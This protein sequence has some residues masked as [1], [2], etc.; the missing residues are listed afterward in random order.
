MNFTIEPRRRIMKALALT[1][2][3]VLLASACGG[4][5]DSAAPT[6]AVVQTTSA[7][8][9]A[10]E[11]HTTT[12][13]GPVKLAAVCTF[14]ESVP[15]IT[16]HASGA[17]Q[18]SQLRWD[19]NIWGWNTGPSYEIR[20]EQEHQ[21]VPQVV[22][23]LQECRG[24]TCET[25]ETTIATSIIA[26]TS[27]RETGSATTVTPT[28]AAQTDIA[29]SVRLTAL[30]SFDQ[31]VPKITCHASGATQGSQLRWESNVSGWNTGPSYE[32]DLAQM[33][34]PVPQVVVTLQ[35]CHGPSCQT[36]E[37][38]IDTSVFLADSGASVRGRG[39]AQLLDVDE[40]VAAWL[41]RDTVIKA[42][43]LQDPSSPVVV[44]EV[45]SPG[46]AEDFFRDSNY[47]YVSGWEGFQILRS[48]DPLGEPLGTIPDGHWS[49]TI[50]EEGTAYLASSNELLIL[51][52]ETP[53]NLVELSRTTYVGSAPNAM[54]LDEDI[55]Y[56]STILGG[57]LNLIDVSDPTSPELLSLIQFEHNWAGLEVW[58]SYVYLVHGTEYIINPESALGFDSVSVMKVI[59]ISDPLNPTI[60]T[61]L[62]LDTDVRDIV[63]AEDLI[64]VF[65]SFT[66]EL[67]VIDISSPTSPEL[68][69]GPSTND[70]Q[71]PT[72]T[73]TYSNGDYVYLL[74][75][76]QG[77]RVVDLSNPRDPVLVKILDLPMQLSCI[78]GSHAMLY[79]CAE[80]RYFNLADITDP[81]NPTLLYS[82]D[83][84]AGSFPYTSIDLDGG[85]LFF[86][87]V[88]LQVYDISDPGSP[89]KIS[90]QIGV[91]A[92]AVHNDYLFS[93]IGE[94]GLDVY[95]I[96]NLA[97]PVHVARLPMNAGDFSLDGDWL[98]G[99]TNIPNS[100]TVVDVSDPSVPL[101][102]DSLLF[103]TEPRSVTT[104]DGYVYVAFGAG[105]RGTDIYM[106]DSKG[107]LVFES[108]IPGKTDWS[109][110]HSVTVV[111]D[112]AYVVSGGESIKIFDISDRKHPSQLGELHAKGMAERAKVLDGYIYVADA[113]FGLTVMR[114]DS[115]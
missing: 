80:E 24:S 23:T 103:E 60:R 64:Y 34:Q 51:D 68:L 107:L 100:I 33:H 53:Q 77:I 37:T 114:L 32:L 17:T 63:R 41:S 22:V 4:S 5:L 78:H 76:G 28:T 6:T 40:G 14:D 18:G 52:V 15:M 10:T 9:T 27:G 25:V 2:M 106:I 108:N 90:V 56:L 49:E 85:Y 115:D 66:N 96:S 111:S 112:R 13:T 87:S 30:C 104:K 113:N 44:G 16:C 101:I 1:V 62:N 21:L 11:V 39:Y 43:S 91:D 35:E 83:A 97:N 67:S 38:T 31:S 61:Q 95:D 58:D 72:I 71:G 73:G 59:D 70:F 36:V 69:D 8:P 84:A 81:D 94:I 20:I 110:S 74:D 105:I 29:P 89:E 50:V 99:I 19:S 7:A 47:F 79:V 46:H 45:D 54:K 48:D 26:T 102:T 42:I 55:L 88:G 57:G 82:G 92:L 3:P 75:S 109:S 98:V 65:G 93:M 12:A 86:N